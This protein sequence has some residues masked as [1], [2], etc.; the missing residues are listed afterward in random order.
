MAAGEGGQ[1]QPRARGSAVSVHPQRRMQAIYRKQAGRSIEGRGE[2]GKKLGFR[3]M[4]GTDRLSTGDVGRPREFP[5]I[6]GPTSIAHMKPVVL[7]LLQTPPSSGNET[8][9]QRDRG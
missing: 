8:R 2:Q 9:R 6:D 7:P 3:S 4:Y 1:K 5:K